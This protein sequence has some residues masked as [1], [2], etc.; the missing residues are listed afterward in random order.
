VADACAFAFAVVNLFEDGG[1]S[2][3]RGL[4]VSSPFWFAG[5]VLGFFGLW[6][7]ERFE[8]NGFGG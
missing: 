5:G 6:F 1:A 8:L 7:V 3:R 4:S 2:R